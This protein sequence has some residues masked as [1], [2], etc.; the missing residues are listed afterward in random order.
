MSQIFARMLR[1]SVTPAL[2]AILLVGCNDTPMQSSNGSLSLSLRFAA[3]TAAT[4]LPK[5]ST[6]AAAV[7]SIRL[8]RVRVVLSKI[9]LE[10]FNDSAE[11]RSAPMILELNL[12]GA[13]QT[14]G[15]TGVPF[16]TYNE[17][18]FKIHR[19]DST[20]LAAL[21]NAQDFLQP[22]R[23]SIIAEGLVYS[24]GA[25]QNFSYRSG[26]NVEQEYDL[27]PPLVVSADNPTANLTINVDA[28]MWFKNSAGVLLDPTDPNNQNQIANNIKASFKVY[29][30]DDRDGDDDDDDNDDD[31]DDDND[32]GGG[33]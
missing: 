24:N 13:L 32:D 9:E 12:T 7:D 14:L 31:D 20:D 8:T 18:E 17:V 1:W 16:G 33:D 22:S 5:V 28:T 19:V 10:A 3:N 27:T 25:A 21:P 26:L 6:L 11:F 30:D 2:L 4:A 15:V 23:A 29:E